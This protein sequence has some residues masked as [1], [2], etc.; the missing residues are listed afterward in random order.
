MIAIFISFY[1]IC[2]SRFNEGRRKKEEGRRRFIYV[3][4]EPNLKR[5]TYIRKKEEGRRKKE[6]GGLYMWI[7]T[8]T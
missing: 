3:D 7:Q 2:V 1:F 8:P 4:S 6:E 5:K